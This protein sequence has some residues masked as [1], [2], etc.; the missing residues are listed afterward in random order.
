M[1]YRTYIGEMPKREYNKIKSMT[2]EQLVEFYNIE[3]EISYN[4]EESWY[5]GVYEFG[6]ELHEFG[7]YTDFSPPKKSLKPF[8]KNK[9]L[10]ERYSDNDF[11]VVTKEFLAYVI[12]SYQARIKDYYN[13][14]VNPFFSDDNIFSPQSGFIDSIKKKYN[15]PNINIEFDFSKITQEQQNALHSMIEHVRS[16][17]MEWTHMTPFHLD[18]GDAITLSW[19]YEYIIFE[20]VKIYKT[21]DWKRKVMIYYGY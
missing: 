18:N 11:Y 14:M 15:F 17:K 3:K 19:K 8:F 2:E 6:K 13:K 5:K 4:G 12:E 16:M 1:G 9:Q 21:F 20:L 10:M 7:K